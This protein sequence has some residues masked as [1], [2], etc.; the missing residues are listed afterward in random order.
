MMLWVALGIIFLFFGPRSFLKA[1]RAYVAY[2]IIA[3]FCRIFFWGFVAVVIASLLVGTDG[4]ER[5]ILEIFRAL[6]PRL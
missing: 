2:R 5:T 3:F 1:L 6:A 4:V